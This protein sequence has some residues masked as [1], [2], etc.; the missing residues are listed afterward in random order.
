M[1]Y[2]GEGS[3]DEVT[4]PEEFAEYVEPH[5]DVREIVTMMCEIREDSKVPEDLVVDVAELEGM[6][7]DQVT[8]QIRE[9]VSTVEIVE[10]DEGYL[11][12]RGHFDEGFD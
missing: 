10:L 5:M 11:Q 2:E 3:N 12:D 8:R 9:F 6:E 7:R 1:T 4:D